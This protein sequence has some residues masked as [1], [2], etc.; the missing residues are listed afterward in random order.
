VGTLLLLLLTGFGGPFAIAQPSVQLD[1][2]ISTDSTVVGERFTVSLVAT[3]DGNTTVA[4]PAADAGPVVFGKIDVL[5]RSGMLTRRLDDGSVADSVVYTATT[6]AL[7]SVELPAVPVQIAAEGDTTIATAPARTLTVVSVVPSD[8]KGI[9]GVAPP[10]P[11]PRPL[12]TWLLLGLVILGLLAGLAYLWWRRRQSPDPASATRPLQ[13]DKTPYEAATT[14][15]R[16]L[17]SYDLSDPDAVKPFYVELSN[18]LRVYLAR[19]LEV[20]ALERTTR[21]VVEVL[22]AR[23]DVPSEAAAR[24][25]AVLELADLVKFADAQPTASDHEKALQEARTA[26]DTL[27][28]TR[29]QNS[30]GGDGRPPTPEAVDGVASAA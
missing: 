2:R 13:Q 19:E 21:E 27:E 11:F 9:H 15:I 24:I 6:F 3:H 22:E 12:W 25:R 7:D 10:A 30:P 17:E 1:T 23:P 29:P 28:A 26:L 8:A 14:W 4:F 16:Q 18:A 20:A 5:D